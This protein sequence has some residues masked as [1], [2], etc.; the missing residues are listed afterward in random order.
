MTEIYICTKSEFVP[1]WFNLNCRT[2]SVTY[3][4]MN[5]CRAVISDGRLPLSNASMLAYVRINIL[6]FITSRSLDLIAF[7]LFE[8]V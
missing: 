4:L 1:E 3:K 2:I 8:N 7:E 6:C 5:Y